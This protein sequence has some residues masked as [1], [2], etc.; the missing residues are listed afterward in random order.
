ML[1]PWNVPSFLRNKKKINPKFHMGKNAFSHSISKCDKAIQQYSW[2]H[3][4]NFVPS[5]SYL[6]LKVAKQW[7][8]K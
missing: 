2:L 5:L 7:I 8:L 1:V 3:W 6:L 4:S